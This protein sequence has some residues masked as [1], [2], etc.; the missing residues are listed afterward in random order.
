MDT[1]LQ[2][3]DSGVTFETTMGN[4]LNTE[5]IPADDINVLIAFLISISL[6]IL[7]VAL[8]AYIIYA[9][10]LSR[11]FK[12]AG[13]ESWK[14]WVPVY[15]VWKILEIGGQKGFWAILA[16]VPIINIASMIFTYIAMYHIGLKL[17][18]KDWFILLA[19]FI[20]IVWYGWLALD[21]SK[22]QGDDSSQIPAS[23]QPPQIP[24]T[25]QPPVA[26]QNNF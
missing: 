11:I 21:G 26:P 3:E 1:E 24:N 23:P 2:L 9:F 25:P 12:K 8:V 15:N 6:F 14:A 13:V 16:F 19:I 4:S 10:L 20:P 17:G 18:K 7:L 5:S 22:W